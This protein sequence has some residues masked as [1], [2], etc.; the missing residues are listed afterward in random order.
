MLTRLL[1]HRAQIILLTVFAMSTLSFAQTNKVVPDYLNVPGPIVFD[2]N[3]F[4]LSWSAHPSANFYKQEYIVKGD[5]EGKY[6]TMVLID[7]ITGQQSVKSIV[8][9]KVEELKTMKETNPVVNYEV[10]NNPSTGEYLLDFLLTA[11]ASDGTINIVERNV[12]RYKTFATKTGQKGVVLFG[13]S[14]RGYGAGVDKFFA[15]LKINRKDL[16]NKVA[17]FKMPEISIK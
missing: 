4:N 1:R 10:I 13:I 6:K 3:S 5:I 14:T 15:A 7:V 12:Y 8:A 9:A 16:I 17:Q 2:N 11:N